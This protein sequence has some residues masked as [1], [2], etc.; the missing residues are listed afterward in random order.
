MAD[1][2][3]VKVKLCWELAS[4]GV[5]A[6]KLNLVALFNKKLNYIPSDMH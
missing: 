3:S 4:D 5:A 1:K 2:M 6:A